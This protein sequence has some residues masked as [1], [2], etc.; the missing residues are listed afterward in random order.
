M[1]LNHTGLCYKGLAF[2]NVCVLGLCLQSENI[3]LKMALLRGCV[4]LPPEVGPA[5]HS[6]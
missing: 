6:L 1:W 5:T 3:F 4:A 2:T